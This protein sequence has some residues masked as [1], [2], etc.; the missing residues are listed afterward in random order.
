MVDKLIKYIMVAV[1]A[2]VILAL[3]SILAGEIIIASLI[4]TYG[5]MLDQ[6]ASPTVTLTPTPQPTVNIG[7]ALVTQPL[8][9]HHH[10]SGKA[11]S[12]D[13]HTILITTDTGTQVCVPTGAD[14]DYEA[15]V[16]TSGQCFTITVYN[17]VGEIVYSTNWMQFSPSGNDVKNINSSN[18]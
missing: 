1:V 11:F 12:D 18:M 2:I 3:I 13:T 15:D 10:I 8:L 7:P 9:P 17:N 16:N 4:I 6:H 14:G 5:G